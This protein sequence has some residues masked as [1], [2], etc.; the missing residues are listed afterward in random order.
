MKSLCWL[1]CCS[2]VLGHANGVTV[3]ESTLPDSDFDDLETSR[4]I[5]IVPLDLNKVRLFSIDLEFGGS[6][7]SNN[8]EIAMGCSDNEGE[9]PAENIDFILGISCGTWFLRERG[10]RRTYTCTNDFAK[11]GAKKLRLA[12][13]YDASGLPQNIAFMDNGT[14]FNFHGLDISAPATAAWL[15][16]TWKDMKLTRRGYV[17]DPLDGIRVSIAANSTAIII[18]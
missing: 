7:L 9:L 6:T 4:H 2:L 10:L 15:R 18:R 17:E 11:T 13:R 14:P 8:Y 1:F 5:K 12:I 16:P 3:N